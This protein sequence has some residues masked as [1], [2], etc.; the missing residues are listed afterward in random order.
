MEKHSHRFIDDI[1]SYSHGDLITI[2][3]YSGGGEGS[4]ADSEDAI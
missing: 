4:I 1:V 3:T 2:S